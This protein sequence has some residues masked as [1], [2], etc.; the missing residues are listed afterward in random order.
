M[1]S[2]LWKSITLTVLH[3]QINDKWVRLNPI[4]PSSQHSWTRL[5]NTK[6]TTTTKKNQNP[7]TTGL[8]KR[9]EKITENKEH[10]WFQFCKHCCLALFIPWS[11]SH[12]SIILIRSNH[13]RNQCICCQSWTLHLNTTHFFLIRSFFAYRLNKS[14]IQLKVQTLRQCPASSVLQCKWKTW[15]YIIT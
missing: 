7:E 15:Q 12:Y 14:V 5:N 6:T 4:L 9:N 11:A 2:D 3:P 8:L 13:H 10:K 1:G